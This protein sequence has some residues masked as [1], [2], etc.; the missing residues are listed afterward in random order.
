MK[1]LIVNTSKTIGG[2]AIAASRLA[3][4]LQK[5]G[6]D[7]AF[8]SRTKKFPSFYWERFVIYAKNKFSRKNL[9]AVDIANAG[10]DI[11]LDKAFQEA[12]IVHLHWVNQGFLSL[13]ILDK[14]FKSG[15][16]VVWTMHDM[17]PCTAIC[18]HAKDCNRFMSECKYCNLLQEPS[19]TDMAN[20]VFQSKKQIYSK[21]RLNIVAVS[22]WLADK[23]CSSVL[24]RDKPVDVIPN[25]ISLEQFD[26]LPKNK[27]RQKLGLPIDRHLII[28]GAARLDDSIKG[29]EFLVAALN[30]LVKK[31]MGNLH[32][33]LFGN[34]KNAKDKF[35]SAI[36]VPYTYFGLVNESMLPEMF[37]AADVAV[38]ASYYETFGLTLIEAQACGCIPVSFNNSGQTDIIQHK[39]NGYLAKYKSSDDLAN[40][41]EWALTEGH[42]SVNPVQL[43]QSVIEKYSDSVVARRYVDLY[44][45]L[46]KQNK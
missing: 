13:H 12:D 43:R 20:A 45:K 22:T 35:L 9:F 10:Q 32:L 7:V 42:E 33:A 3:T 44:E 30:T 2:A 18:H 16:P 14:I 6:I 36:P 8:V 28:F 26:M 21:A 1:V 19:S 4:A 24:L 5:A 29:F 17:W 15:K 38:S 34:I 31:G 27:S 11:T 41:I 40:G 25:T 37:S 23:V 46:K 39:I